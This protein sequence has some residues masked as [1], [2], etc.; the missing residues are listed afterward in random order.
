MKFRCTRTSTSYFK[1]WN[2]W[3]TQDIILADRSLKCF[4]LWKPYDFIWRGG[5]GF[6]LPLVFEKAIWAMATT[7]AHNWPKTQS[8]SSSSRN[9]VFFRSNRPLSKNTKVGLS[10]I[11]V[12]ATVL[13][14]GKLVKYSTSITFKRK[15]PFFTRMYAFPIFFLFLLINMK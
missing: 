11:K 1:C 12:Q 8:R 10:F 6:E 3:K 4:R 9:T 14:L 5:C 13:F 15:E 2:N 7:F